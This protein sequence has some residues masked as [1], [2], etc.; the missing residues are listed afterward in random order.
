MA[1]ATLPNLSTVTAL[2]QAF[3]LSAL[4]FSLPQSAQAQN[5]VSGVHFDLRERDFHETPYAMLN[6][7]WW[8]EFGAHLTPEEAHDA[9]IAENLDAIAVPSDWRDTLTEANTN[10]FSHGIATYLSRISLPEDPH[11]HLILV[12]PR[13]ADAYVVYWIPANDPANWREL[14]ED[15]TLSGPI[16]PAHTMRAYSLE[17]FSDGYLM[18]HVRKE[19]QSYGGILRAPYIAQSGAY[20]NYLQMLRLSDGMVMGITLFVSIFN[21]FLFLLYRKDPATL[22][23]A[24][25][26][27]A[28]FLR[29]LTMTGTLEIILG[30][31]LRSFLT[32]LEIA[33]IL[34]IAW[35][36]YAM[37]QALLWRRF[38]NLKG[39]ILIGMV[40]MLGAAFIFTAPLPQVTE[41]I[42]LV[43]LYCFATFV[44]ILA[45]S[46]RAIKLKQPDAW[47]YS[48]GWLLPM[49]AGLHDIYTSN[50][51]G[52]VYLANP[53]FVI[54]ISVYS[55]KVGHRVITELNRAEFLRQARKNLT[56]LHQNAMASARH[57]QLT[58]L[59]DRHAFD[60]E[61]LLAWQEKDCCE[62]GLSLVVLEIESF[63]AIAATHGQEAADMTLRSVAELLSHSLL[64][65]TDR[66]CRY[67]EASFMFLLPCANGSKAR[68]VAER[69]RHRIKLHEVTL[70][71]GVHLRLQASFGHATAEPN[72]EGH[73]HQLVQ[74]AQLA[75]DHAQT[76][77][78]GMIAGF[79]ALTT[80]QKARLHYRQ[81]SSEAN[82][83][84]E[85]AHVEQHSQSWTKAS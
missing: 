37:H 60:D 3:L 26:G 72:A 57:D 46:A 14:G 76:C 5:A 10:P 74:Q 55:W 20:Q 25:G 78:T 32:R 27:F 71:A 77:G 69:V 22:I 59:L 81:T 70:D 39:P 82:S 83:D 67:Q 12:L 52:G 31:N 30:M 21:L 58:G 15:G 34:L 62:D 4:M 84:I 16:V 29:A 63:Q 48:V 11:N 44:L 42:Y 85:A 56:E 13:V 75:L 45:T 65:K 1:R 24:L 53:A 61:L 38:S 9:F 33:D 79:D 18:V 19:L 6:G 51:F 73:C 66:I 64:R 23:L 68:E 47:F 50:Q 41:A 49:T 8:F 40:G 2:F 36:T 17:D 28:L 43:H 54:F 35:T 7:D 80:A